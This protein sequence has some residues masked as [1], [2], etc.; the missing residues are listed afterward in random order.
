MADFTVAIPVYNGA[1]FLEAALE[2]IAAQDLE[3]VEVLV[4][5]NASTDDTPAIL[6]RWAA[7]LPLRVVRRAQTLPM[8]DH[9]NALLDDVDSPAYMLLCHDDYLAHPDALRLA[10]KAMADNPDIA[11]VYC[12]MLYVDEAGQQLA[13]R[14]FGRSGRFNPDEIGRR[15][16]QTGRNLFGIPLAIRTSALGNLR[17]DEQFLYAM[18]IDL[19]W[20]L[21]AAG[22]A[23]HIDTPLIANRYSADNTTWRLLGSTVGEYRRLAAK[24]VGARSALQDTR[25][26]LTC[27]FVTAQKLAFRFYAKARNWR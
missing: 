17:Y 3:G 10:R 26:A 8:R 1:R 2:S 14:S 20:A 16:L 27:H 24:H 21:G 12:D 6:E 25:L 4:S 7:R 11:T 9:F 15:C 22:D 5:D 18:D 13:R 23:W 19:S